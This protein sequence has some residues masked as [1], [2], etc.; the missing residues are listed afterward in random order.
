MKEFILVEFN[1]RREV[2]IDENASGYD[3]GDVIDLVPGTHTIS[4]E[5]PPDFSPMEQDVNPS[6]TSSLRPHIIHFH[7]V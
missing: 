5:G 4:L 3:T 2:I 1:E 6:G 7:K